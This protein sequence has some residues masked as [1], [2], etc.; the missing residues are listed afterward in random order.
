MIYPKFMKNALFSLLIPSMLWANGGGYFRPGLGSAGSITLFEPK[1]TQHVQMVDEVL[2]I[3]VGPESAEVSI[4]YRMKNLR[5][6]KSKVEFGFPV[7]SLVST[8]RPDNMPFQKIN[9]CENYKISI[10]EKDVEGKLKWDEKV[11][12]M[13]EPQGFD[14]GG[15]VGLAGWMVSSA[16]FKANEE[17]EVKIRFRSPYPESSF[18]GELSHDEGGIKFV[19]RLSSA[20]CWAGTIA[21]G[22]I[23]INIP[24]YIDPREVVVIKP[25]NRFKRKGNQLAW[26][27]ENLE[28]TFADDLEVQVKPH[29]F[30]DGREFGKTH[31]FAERGGKWEVHHTNYQIKASSTLPDE[32]GLSYKADNLRCS[33]DGNDNGAWSE[34][35][36]GNGVGE[37]LEIS[38]DVP[39]A[40]RAVVLSSG[41]G[42][43]DLFSFN[44]RP[45]RMTLVLNGEKSYDFPI[46]DQPDPQR[47]FLPDYSKPVS[48]IKITFTEVYPGSKYEDMCVSGL[49]LVSGLSKK[50]AITPSR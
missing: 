12:K 5:D 36:K 43:G 22:K 40:L 39:T 13:S 47:F 25:V 4:D 3:D 26:E 17:K 41:Y 6:K 48:K 11:K 31:S 44:A 18:G 1:G 45:K 34:G 42:Y 37:W 33:T 46:M 20:A 49:S 14:M 8:Y 21:K 9:Y 16:D 19:Y 29:I 32:K 27:F 24:Q 30:D 10:G 50:P 23:T 38:P 28:P 15:F 7:E 2:T 35:A